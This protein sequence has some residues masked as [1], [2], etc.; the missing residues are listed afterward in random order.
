MATSENLNNTKGTNP[1]MLLEV[2]NY[3]SDNSCVI[4]VSWGIV[5][6]VVPGIR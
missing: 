1:S 2:L 6:N 5:L 3:L 4:Y